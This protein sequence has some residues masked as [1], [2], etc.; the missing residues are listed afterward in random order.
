MANAFK[1]EAKDFDRLVAYIQ[2]YGDGAEDVIND[3]FE[4][5]AVP[6]VEERITALLPTSGRTWK[7]KKRPA[8]TSKPFV[9]QM[10]NLAFIIRTKSA[11]NYLYFPDDGS[12]TRK[13]RGNKQFMIRG[14][15]AAVDSVIDQ[16]LARLTK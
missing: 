1:I 4:S 15:E 7:G 9:H 3:V 16:C 13:H 10:L 6:E 2:E 11:Y 8:K 5:F 12:N 14:A